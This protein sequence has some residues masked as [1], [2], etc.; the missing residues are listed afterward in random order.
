MK[1]ARHHHEKPSPLPNRRRPEVLSRIK[2]QH[3]SARGQ[4]PKAKPTKPMDAPAADAQPKASRDE[5][6]QRSPSS[7]ELGILDGEVF[8]SAVRRMRLQVQQPE[9][10]S[11]RQG[12]ADRT[13]CAEGPTGLGSGV[14]AVPATKVEFRFANR[15][16]SAEPLQGNRICQ[17]RCADR[18]GTCR[19]VGRSDCVWSSHWNV[20]RTC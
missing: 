14:P 17:D 11:F 5:V 9:A 18:P 7:V 6:S 16:E 4:V 1:A 13:L 19:S 15:V 3:S 10:A 8:M 2:V 20:A 12:P